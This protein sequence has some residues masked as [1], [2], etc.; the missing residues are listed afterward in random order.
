MEK[1]IFYKPPYII[2]ITW[3]IFPPEEMH[4]MKALGWCFLKF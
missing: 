2:Y 3:G 1:I 4:V